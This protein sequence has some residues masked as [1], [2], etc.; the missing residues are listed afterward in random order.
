M[1]ILAGEIVSAGRLGLLQPTT[2]DA[3]CTSA[4]TVG[5]AEA[6]VVGASITFTTAGANAIY[7][8]EGIFD[9]IVDAAAAGTNVLG[10]CA[11]DGA[12]LGASAVYEMNAPD[13]GPAN[14]IWRGTLAS[15]GSHTIK[16]LGNKSTASGVARI[17]NINT[18][19]HLTIYEVV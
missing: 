17:L 11:V 2:Y 6:D 19:I 4:L 15:A 3:A 9:V 10:R 18:T 13:R 12:S 8:V 7:V 14:Q 5:T 1:A 16:L